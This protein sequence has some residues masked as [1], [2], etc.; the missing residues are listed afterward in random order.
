MV[1]PS[2]D[3]RPSLPERYQQFLDLSEINEFIEALEVAYEETHNEKV[4]R[5]L[6]GLRNAKKRQLTLEQFYRDDELKEFWENPGLWPHAVR[7]W[8]ME[9]RD[10]ELD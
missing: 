1:A 10:Q 3:R 4:Y 8:M 2:G 9:Y 6:R 7:V 5:V